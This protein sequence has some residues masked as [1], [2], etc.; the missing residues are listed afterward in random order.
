MMLSLF[1][2]AASVCQIQKFFISGTS[3]TLQQLHF[4]QSS[5]LIFS[6]ENSFGSHTHT[7]TRARSRFSRL[8]FAVASSLDLQLAKIT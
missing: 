6:S 8:I 4:P 7:H 5:N 3:F 1:L 2:E